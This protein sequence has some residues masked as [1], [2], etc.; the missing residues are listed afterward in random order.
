VEH[1]PA[2]LEGFLAQLSL[3]G[4]IE[5]FLVLADW[6]QSKGDLWGELIAIQ[7]ASRDLLELHA[8]MLWIEQERLLETIGRRLCP[9]YGQ[10]G[11]MVLWGRGF[12]RYVA[13]REDA[14]PSELA[15][16]L[17]NLF[18]RPAARLFTELSFE[19]AHLDST[20]LPSLMR[21]RR[22]LA[23]M[24]V[25]NFEGNWFTPDVIRELH[26]AFPRALLGNQREHPDTDAEGPATLVKSWGGPNGNEG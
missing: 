21:V 25:L 17:V 23:R 6:L 13:F 14:A 1:D 24:T 8:S 2:E 18:E 19:N 16:D 10:I 12:V 3:D 15:S 22:E 5:P 20:H 9:L 4:P 26:L 11:R 7:C